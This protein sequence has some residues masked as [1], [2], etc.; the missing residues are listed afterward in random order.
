[1]IGEKR[2]NKNF[3]YDTPG[4]LVITYLSAVYM[5]YNVMCTCTVY[6][7]TYTY[8]Y[9]CNIHNNVYAYCME[10][11]VYTWS[12]LVIYFCSNFCYDFEFWCVNGEHLC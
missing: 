3:Q 5:V 10:I 2:V 6:T 11:S 7:C 12:A 8:M 1:M 9:T 4:D